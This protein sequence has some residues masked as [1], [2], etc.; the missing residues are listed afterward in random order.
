ME[1]VIRI[2]NSFD[3]Q[4]KD[5]IIYWR[6]LSGEKKL[7]I[8]EYIR[9]NYWAIKNETPQRLQRIYRITERV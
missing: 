9:A 8:L 1:K 6:N 3:E 5:D 4:E 2:Y 7:E